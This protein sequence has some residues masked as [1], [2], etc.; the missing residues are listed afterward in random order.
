LVIPWLESADDR[1]ALYGPDWQDSTQA[2]QETYI[3][4]WLAVSAGLPL[5][6]DPETGLQIQFYPARYHAGLSSIFA[7]GDFC[8]R[9]I[10]P[11]YD[12]SSSGS[13]RSAVCILE[14]PEHLNYYRK[15]STVSSREINYCVLVV[16]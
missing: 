15:Y 4:Q 3:R 9:L 1:V 8:E 5:E 10:V 6:A 14:E 2:E 11:E 16:S 7:M 12:E 13:N